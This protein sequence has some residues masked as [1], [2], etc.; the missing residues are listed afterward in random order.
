MVKCFRFVCE[1]L[2]T[3]PFGKH[4]VAKL[5]SWLLVIYSLSR[6]T[7][8]FMRNLQRSNDCSTTT[9]THAATLRPTAHGPD[10]A[11]AM[12]AGRS[13]PRGRYSQ[14]RGPLPKLRWTDLLF[15]TRTWLRYVQTFL[16][17]IRLSVLCNVRAPYSTGWNFRQCFYAI[18]YLSH[19]LTP[20]L[21]FT[22][23]VPGEPLRR[24]LN[25]RGVVIYS[26]F[27]PVDTISR[28]RCKIRPRVQLM[29]NRKLYP[30]NPM[31]QLW[32]L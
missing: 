19:P 32:T 17:Q 27:G 8:G 25:A 31:V 4:I 29:T 24:R 7:L 12:H 20:M 15:F 9:Q 16:S 21:N 28:K 30:Q 6:S 26:D 1:N 18:S 11:L 13:P 5:D 3:F 22:K 10:C 2:P 14:R 23:I